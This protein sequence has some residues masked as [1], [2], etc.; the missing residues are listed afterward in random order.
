V[1]KETVI[2][3]LRA[4]LA[5][6]DDLRSLFSKFAADKD[7]W[8]AREE[9]E[10]F[11][12]EFGHEWNGDFA[13][14]AQAFYDQYFRDLGVPEGFLPRVKI[15]DSRRG[16]W[17]IDAVLTLPAAIGTVYAV[18]QGIAGLPELAEKLE[19]TKKQVQQ[20]LAQRFSKKV[21]Q[22]VEPIISHSA[23]AHH[24]PPAV[25]PANVVSTSFSIDA[26]PLRGLTPDA[27]KAHSIH[28]AVAVSRS[29]ISVENLG[30]VRIDNLHIGIFKSASQAHSWNFADA[31]S[32]NVPSLSAKQSLSITIH[33]FLSQADQA[34]LDLLDPSPLYVD[35]WLQDNNGIYLFNFYVE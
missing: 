21:R 33:E 14:V 7:A 32:K 28:L 6:T 20:E 15:T 13:G 23:V 1:E 22:R 24:R 2:A 9:G 5:P 26:R 27:I 31:F 18:M 34:K 4:E 19:K 10:F 35:C 17:I 3:N 8:F 25:V 30:D 11:L 12:A 16:S 29:A